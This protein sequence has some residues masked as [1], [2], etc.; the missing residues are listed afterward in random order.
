M[1]RGLPLLSLHL[2]EVVELFHWAE[3]VPPLLLSR[4]PFCAFTAALAVGGICPLPEELA[5][6]IDNWFADVVPK[7]EHK[8]SDAAGGQDASQRRAAEQV[9]R[10]EVAVNGAPTQAEHGAAVVILYYKCVEVAAGGED[11]LLPLGQEPWQLRRGAARNDEASGA[12]TAKHLFVRLLQPVVGSG[13]V[14]LRV[15]ASV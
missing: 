1:R 13:Y 9:T 15:C 10:K 11:W 12:R 8:E 7:S 5:V 2:D 14:C 4:R 3:A 6:G